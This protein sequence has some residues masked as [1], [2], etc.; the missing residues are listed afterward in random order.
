MSLNLYVQKKMKKNEVIQ[1]IISEYELPSEY[2]TQEYPIETNLQF[3]YIE[4]YDGD[5]SISLSNNSTVIVV[6]NTK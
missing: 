5:V 4:K 3:G 2:T 6:T 1:K